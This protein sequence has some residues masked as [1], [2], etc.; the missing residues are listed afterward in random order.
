ML[1]QYRFG[2]GVKFFDIISPIWA[3]SFRRF[4]VLHSSVSFLY[5]LPASHP[6]AAKFWRDNLSDKT[7]ALSLRVACAKA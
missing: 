3:Q 7:C 4:V 2:A 6:V 5:T 1:K